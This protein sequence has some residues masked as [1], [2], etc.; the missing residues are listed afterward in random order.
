MIL[1]HISKF[2]FYYFFFSDKKA[3]IIEQGDEV[4]RI[5]FEEK[6]ESVNKKWISTDDSKIKFITQSK[7]DFLNLEQKK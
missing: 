1:F 7:E 4:I 3:I 6:T 5:K 2:L